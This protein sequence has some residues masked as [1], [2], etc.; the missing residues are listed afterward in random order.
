[1]IC[2]RLYSNQADILARLA[3]GLDFNAEET[4][5]VQTGR[6]YHPLSSFCVKVQAVG[7]L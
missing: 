7:I 1:M 5:Q 3:L 2:L 4:G 6:A